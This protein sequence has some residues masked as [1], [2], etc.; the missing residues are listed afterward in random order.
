MEG[1]IYNKSTAK[2]SFK[3][4]E[5]TLDNFNIILANPGQNR[6]KF[7]IELSSDYEDGVGI[8]QKAN[9]VAY[10]AVTFNRAGKQ[11]EDEVKPVVRPVPV[12]REEKEAGVER[13]IAEKVRYWLTQ[14]AEFESLVA[15]KQ[16]LLAARSS[17]CS[18]GFTLQDLVYTIIFSF[19][20]G[21]ILL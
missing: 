7:L 16:G 20:L 2:I 10:L 15:T 19:M 21:F 18:S 8:T 12:A 4:K 9:Q 6:E 13:Q 5:L 11:R 1:Q 14:K 3:R 17:S